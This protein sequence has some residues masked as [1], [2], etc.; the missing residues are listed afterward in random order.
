MTALA[1]YL[2]NPWREAAASAT[3][4]WCADE[5]HLAWWHQLA[6]DTPSG[7]ALLAAL[8]DAL[9]TLRLAIAAGASAHPAYEALIRQA[10]PFDEVASDPS[11]EIPLEGP[12]AR[13]DSIELTIAEH[14]AGALPVLSIADRDDFLRCYRALG[15]RGEPIDVPHG[16]HALYVSGLPNPGR[17]RALRGAWLEGGN[18][19]AAWPAEMARLAALDRT[20]F[21]DRIVLVEPGGY[22]EVRDGWRR[23]VASEPAWL[24]A[25]MAIRIEHE[26]AHHATHRLFGSHRLHLHDELIADFMGFSKVLGAFDAALFLEALGLPESHGAPVPDGARIRHYLGGLD[27]HDLPALRRLLADAATNVERVAAALPPD[28]P[29]LAI[30]RTLAADGLDEIAQPSWMDIALATLAARAERFA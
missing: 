1:A 27:E 23:H 12:F 30:L 22:G 6:P 24:D 11:I 15:T 17:L 25:S 4:L 14:P 13:P 10:R 5:A 16:V 18:D 8:H 7:T 19:L 20:W 2:E 21:H 3:D 29:R 28:T 26:F 9:P